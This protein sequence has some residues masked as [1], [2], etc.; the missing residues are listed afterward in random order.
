MKFCKRTLGIRDSSSNW[1]SL[2][3]CGRLPSITLIIQRMLSYWYHVSLS[4][5]PIVRAALKVN[6]SLTASGYRGWFSYVTRCL[7]FLGIEHIIYT[8]DITEI[9]YQLNRVKFL[10]NQLAERHW[11]NMHQNISSKGSKLDLFGSLK[12]STGIFPY[13]AAQSPQ[14]PRTR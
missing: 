1:A 4:P 6:A 10:T 12:K 7:K 13:L 11:L 14:K 8:S 2:A 3:E 9:K 5:S